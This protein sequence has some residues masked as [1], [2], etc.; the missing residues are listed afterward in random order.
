MATTWWGKRWTASIES[1]GAVWRNRLPRGRTYARDG[2]V[3]G[4]TVESGRVSAYVVGSLPRP[5]EVTIGL[6]PLTDR[7]WRKVTRKMAGRAAYAARLLAGEMPDDIE[8]AFEAC[9]VSLFPSE[10]IDLKLSCNCPDLAVPCKHIAATHYALGEAFDNDPFLL[11]A[12]RG[13]DRDGV[14]AA[15]RAAR[16]EVGRDDRAGDRPA[17]VAGAAIDPDPASPPAPPDAATG[18]GAATE[19]EPV[20]ADAFVHWRGGAPPELSFR[21]EPPSVRLALLRSLGKPPA[22]RDSDGLPEVLDDAYGAASSLARTIAL[23]EGR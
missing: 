17:A 22:W 13:R 11:F 5:Y 14:L 9:K 10:P 20:D 1:L 16:I 18:D 7:Q 4:L 2:R 8:D 21:I 15:L 19:G 12:L 23:E 3:V 6:R